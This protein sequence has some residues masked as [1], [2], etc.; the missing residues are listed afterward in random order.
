MSLHYKKIFI[1]LIVFFINIIS[2]AVYAK[3]KPKIALVVKSMNNE[4]FKEMQVGAEEYHKKHLDDFDFIFKGTPNETDLNS[5]IQIVD[6]L[7]KMK[8]DALLIAPVDSV[9]ILPSLLKAIKM[10]IIV[11]NIDNK[12][13][14]RSLSSQNINIP[15]IGPSNFN[16]A[17][18]AGL[19]L[20][21]A[22][23]KSGDSVGIIEGLSSS[24][25]A[26]S[27]SDGFRDAMNEG[28]IKVEGVRSGFWEENKGNKAAIEL[29]KEF[30]KIKALLCGN[31]NMALGA[32]KAVEKLNLKGK[33]EIVGYD[34]IP[35]I[36]PYLKSN[37]IFATVDQYPVLQA[38]TGIEMALDAVNN[39]KN[40]SDLPPIVKTKIGVILK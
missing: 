19:A 1:Y 12:I 9:K 14:E 4:F 35:R 25:N 20:V 28:H 38:V 5:Q 16:G 8:I 34:N 21:K 18:E 11:L 23:L 32:L 13:D 33:V 39:K 30:P 6:D 31:D 26:K 3:N 2:I 10:K 22:K 24:V 37:D 40:Q 29:L 27:R 15:F 7:I 36:R 17:K